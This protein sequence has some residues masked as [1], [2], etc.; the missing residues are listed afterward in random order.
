MK[1]HSRISNKWGQFI[2][3][4]GLVIMFFGWM[5][6]KILGPTFQAAYTDSVLEARGL[7][8]EGCVTDK[9]ITYG[10]RSSNYEL[11]YQF[12]VDTSI[13]TDNVRVSKASYDTISI[14]ICFPILYLPNDPSISAPKSHVTI[15]EPVY[16]PSQEMMMI[17]I[18]G[19]MI[20]LAW[21]I[22]FLITF[23]RPRRNEKSR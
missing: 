12:A 19:F 17:G 11:I 9:S 5:I 4:T 18:L 8:V 10:S 21:I 16:F 2:L 7:E 14:G 1:N 20:G 23:F 3:F 6:T 15:S 13:V 22:A